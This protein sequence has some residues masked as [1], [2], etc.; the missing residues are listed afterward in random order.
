MAPLFT[1]KESNQTVTYS[2]LVLDAAQRSALAVTRSLGRAGLSVTTTDAGGQSLAGASRYSTRY[3]QSPSAEHEPQ[4]FIEWLSDVLEERHYDLVLPVTEVTS[5]LILMHRDQL[6]NLPL[7][8]AD[9]DTV[10]ALADKGQLMTLAQELDIPHPATRW[11]ASAQALDR[12]AIDYPAVIKPCLSKVYVGDRWLATRVRVV[13]T[14]AELERELA[15]S[16]YLQDYPFMLQEFIPGR[17]AG[18]FCLYD[19]GRPAA[20]F[21]HRRLREKPPEGGVSV[22][23]ESAPVDPEMQACAR[24][25]LDA[26][27]WHGVAMVEFRISPEGKPYLMEVNTRFWGSLQLAIDA[28]VDF[29]HLLWQIHQG[30]SPTKVDD[31]RLGQRLRWLLGDVD[32]LYLYLRG[33]YT[34]GQKARRLIQFLTPRLR[35]CRHEINRWSDL[36]PAW[37]ELKLYLKQLAGR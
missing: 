15:V 20:F 8:F 9:Y 32:S 34:L 25:L 7:P 23:S 28:G 31:Y 22:L 5:Q 14:P 19:R 17:G 37:Y 30:Q 18:V 13:H 12:E 1:P 33:R 21:A 26:V 6:P 4:A 11:Y 27:K 16:A 10:M 24:R 3:L 35:H 2:A 29:P 36:G